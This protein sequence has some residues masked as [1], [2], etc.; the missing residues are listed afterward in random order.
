MAKSSRRKL[1][2]IACSATFIFLMFVVV[3]W[4]TAMRPDVGY[5]VLFCCYWFLFCL[6][7]GFLFQGLAGAKRNLSLHR[8]GARWV[9]AVALAQVAITGVTVWT[10]WPDSPSAG[11]LVTAAIA[12][13]LNGFSEEFFW[14][15]AWLETGRGDAIFQGI[16]VLL[17]TLWHVPLLL[18]HGVAYPGGPAAL[19]GGG[20][21]LGCIMAFLANR[22]GRIGWPVIAHIGTNL[23]AFPA[24][25][26][27][28]FA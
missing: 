23:F 27:A 14:R 20:F 19:V 2:L 28:N 15:G 16:G 26:A 12:S 8:S 4:A 10:Y 17:F 11:I 24:L 3:P 18:A 21:V 6:P 25:I 22:T 13:L 9:P 7:M 1:A 5:A